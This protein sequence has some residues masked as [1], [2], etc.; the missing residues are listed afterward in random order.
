MG[1]PDLPSLIPDRV[2]SERPQLLTPWGRFVGL[3]LPDGQISGLSVQPL[4]QK[5]F[6]S[7]LTQITCVLSAIPCPRRGAYRDRHGRWA[8]GAMDAR[9]ATDERGLSG[10][11]RRVVLTP[12][13]GVKFLGS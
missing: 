8:R 1:V 5:Y 9:A 12:E 11:R 3:I 4:S 6:T 2:L 7:H 13:A 10:R